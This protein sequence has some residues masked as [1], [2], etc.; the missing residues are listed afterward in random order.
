MSHI[1]PSQS[2]LGSVELV[3][4]GILC[5]LPLVFD[6]LGVPWNIGLQSKWRCLHFCSQTVS[7]PWEGVL[8]HTC[9]KIFVHL[10][11]QGGQMSFLSLTNLLS[12][13]PRLW[14]RGGIGG[15]EG[16]TLGKSRAALPETSKEEAPILLFHPTR[17]TT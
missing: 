8:E 4:I 3:T 11:P 5:V 7:P 10:S 15:I 16:R 1:S 6:I 14:E 2:F 13:R 17:G 9:D 12:L